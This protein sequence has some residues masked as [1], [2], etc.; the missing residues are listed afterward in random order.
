MINIFC[1]SKDEHI[2]LVPVE[3][4]LFEAPENLTSKFFKVNWIFSP[5][6]SLSSRF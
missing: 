1:R 6:A 5:I 2:E 3:E 4:F